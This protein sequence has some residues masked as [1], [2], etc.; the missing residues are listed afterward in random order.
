[1]S[2]QPLSPEE[3]L[4]IKEFLLYIEGNRLYELLGVTQSATEEQ[5]RQGYHSISRQWHPDRFF[6]RDLGNHKENI[7]N[8]FMAIT[9]AYRTLSNITTRK[10]FDRDYI[11]PETQHRQDKDA[12]FHRHHRGKRRRDREERRSER[13]RE[14]A[15]E[16]TNDTTSKMR[17]SR[18]DKI[19]AHVNQELEEQRQKAQSFFDAGKTD[20][21]ENRPIQAA[22]SLHIACKLE[23]NNTEFK[24]LYK[25][26]KKRARKIKAQELFG[27]AENAESFQ[28][29]HEALKQ[30]R[31][32]VEYEVE[33]PRAYARLA[34]LIEKLDPDPRE[35]IKLMQVAVQKDPENAEYRCILGE[36][37]HREGMGLNAKRE[38]HKALEIEKNYSRAKEGLKKL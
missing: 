10:E 2:K 17:S 6:K 19:M 37:Y 14:R 3:I 13:Q 5:I 35:S 31:K 34:Y 7:E 16:A 1:M 29:Y 24:E 30:Y 9:K 8:I 25:T 21:E 20:L 11:P 27:L 22:A 36:I 23:P 38:F 12:T 32:A 33:D 18:K 4:K 26:A 15:A 28:N